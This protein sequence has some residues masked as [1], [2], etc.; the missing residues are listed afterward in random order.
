M[1]TSLRERIALAIEG[2]PYRPEVRRS[3][4]LADAVLAVPELATLAPMLEGFG[5]LLATSSRD[6]GQYAPDAWLYAVICGWDCEET[7]HDETCVHGA[8]EEMAELH[9]WDDATVAKARRYRE[10][11]RAITGEQP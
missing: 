3:V 8:M 4:Q 2:S 9:G 11:V 5:R 6:W 7:E 1:P 10:A